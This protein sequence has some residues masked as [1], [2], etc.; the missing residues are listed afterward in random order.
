MARLLRLAESNASHPSG[1][2]IDRRGSREESGGNVM[3]LDPWYDLMIQ[4]LA[5]TSPD[6]SEPIEEAEPTCAVEES[7]DDK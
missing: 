6:W 7:E 1:D 4:E 2:P 5:E 3:G